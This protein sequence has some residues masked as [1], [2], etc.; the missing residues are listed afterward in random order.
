[1]SGTG[2]VDKG[3]MEVE[4]VG[5][6]AVDGRRRCQVGVAQHAGDVRRIDLD[7]EVAYAEDPLLDLLQRAVESIDFELG[8]GESG[9]AFVHGDRPEPVVVPNRGSYRVALS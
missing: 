3:E 7:D 5:N 2:D 1:M 8:L 4:D 9:F 6:P